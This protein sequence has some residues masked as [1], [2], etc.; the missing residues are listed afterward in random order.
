MKNGGFGKL[1]SVRR[2]FPTVAIDVYLLFYA[3]NTIILLI[4]L[5]Y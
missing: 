3:Q 5:E 1:A 2:R 4:I